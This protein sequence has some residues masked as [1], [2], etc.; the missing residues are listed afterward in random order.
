MGDAQVLQLALPPHLAHG[1][2]MVRLQDLQPGTWTSLHQRA[3][4]PTVT[5]GNWKNLPHLAGGK[6]E[7]SCRMKEP[8]AKLSKLLQGFGMGWQF[9]DCR[10]CPTARGWEEHIPGPSHFG[11]INE[12]LGERPVR[13]QRRALA[14]MA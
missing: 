11:R 4:V 8:S 14:G 3:S 9:L 6:R 1:T 13:Y 7:W 10:L 5:S 12:R 2:P